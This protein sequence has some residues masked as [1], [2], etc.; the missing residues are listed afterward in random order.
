VDFEVE[1]YRDLQLAASEDQVPCPELHIVARAL[2]EEELEV[3]CIVL[4]SDQGADTFEVGLA[5]L[6]TEVLAEDRDKE[7]VV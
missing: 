7:R 3:G 1:Q 6:A 4:A 5:A 2:V